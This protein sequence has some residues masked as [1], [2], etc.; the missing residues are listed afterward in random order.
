MKII[1]REFLLFLCFTAFACMHASKLSQ[2]QT[3]KISFKKQNPFLENKQFASFSLKKL[4]L[5]KKRDQKLF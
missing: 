3:S 5:P 2:S 1:S 4:V